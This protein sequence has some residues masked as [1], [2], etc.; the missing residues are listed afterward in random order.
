M[1]GAAGQVD[2]GPAAIQK[3]ARTLL[4]GI[5]FGERG[6]RSRRVG[7]GLLMAAGMIAVVTVGPAYAAI[8]GRLS[9]YAFAGVAGS[10]SGA[11]FGAAR[12]VP[13]RSAA[14][15]TGWNFSP[16][17]NLRE[18]YDDNIALAAPGRERSDFVT[19]VNP[20]IS[21]DKQTRRFNL[22]AN[23]RMQNLFYAR[24]SASDATFHQL[25]SRMG[26]DLWPGTFSLGAQATASQ[27]LISPTRPVSFGNVSIIG[28][29]TNVF[30]Y[31][32]TPRLRHAFGRTAIVRAHYSY[33]VVDYNAQPL[34]G[35][36]T[37]E[38]GASF[39]TGPDVPGIGFN[40]DYGRS[41]TNFDAALARD[42]IFEHLVGE[43]RYP[44]QSSFRIVLRGGYEDN[45]FQFGSGVTQPKGKLWSGGF[46]WNI[47]PHSYLEARYGRRFFGRA[48]NASFRFEGAW[49][50]AS[51]GFTEA[52]T[53]IS[54]LVLDQQPLIVG[55]NG[56]LI[57]V[58][59]PSLPGLSA[60]VFIN[61]RFSGTLGFHRARDRFSATVSRS[62]R[63]FEL[64][65]SKETVTRVNASWDRRLG[66]RTSTNVTGYWQQWRFIGGVRVDDLWQLTGGLSY[67]FGRYA[68]GTL[69]VTHTQ[70][71][72]NGA[73]DYFVNMVALG[74]TLGF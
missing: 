72:S 57:Q 74:I 34:S 63:T 50:T 26:A 31:K 15:T 51:A 12:R 6:E 42:A 9:G 8:P 4:M 70:R 69:S 48:V 55:P 1:R 60:Q 16:S 5:R 71:T 52:P 30:T 2:G 35:S 61:R 49:T 68:S 17:L 37:G 67:R 24:N 25:F 38:V 62:E 22:L 10:G 13:L 27:A 56:R 44:V 18:I 41:R 47:T 40:V 53:T 39:G 45:N 11:G 54:T 66:A 23:Y 21:I 28:N 29:R 7:G 14:G 33:G 19:E 73:S 43:A 20:E 3:R 59:M 64:T 32:V 65:G 36:Q 46:E 58:M